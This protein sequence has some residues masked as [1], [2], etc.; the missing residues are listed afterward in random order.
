MTLSFFSRPIIVHSVAMGLMCLHSVEVF[1]PLS[2]KDLGRQ[3]SELQSITEL[4]G[5]V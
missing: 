4:L 5:R 2:T 3:F 1:V